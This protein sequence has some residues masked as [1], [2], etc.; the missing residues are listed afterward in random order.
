[1]TNFQ[2]SHSNEQTRNRIFVNKTSSV[3]L[4]HILFLLWCL[5]ASTYDLLVFE[6][7]F[8]KCERQSLGS[9]SMTRMLNANFRSFIVRQFLWKIENL[10]KQEIMK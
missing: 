1:M 3:S 2:N 8:V 6:T 7:N 9:R 5:T 4:H 10:E